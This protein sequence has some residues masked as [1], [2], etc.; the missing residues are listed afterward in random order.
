LGEEVEEELAEGVEVGLGL[1]QALLD[2][3]VEFVD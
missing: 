2:G 1:A 3:V